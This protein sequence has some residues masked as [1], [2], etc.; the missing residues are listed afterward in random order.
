MN[1]V[2]RYFQVQV[3]RRCSGVLHAGVILAVSLFALADAW[4]LQVTPTTLS[5]LAVQGSTSPSGQIL[6]ILKKNDRTLNWSS[7]DNATWL[8][9]SPT[10]GSITS[11]AQISV[12]V[13]PAGLGAGTYTGTITVSV[14]KGGS[15]SVPVTLTVTSGSTSSTSTSLSSSSGTATL[16]WDP[17]TSTNVA[18]YKVYMGTASGTYSAS[19]TVES[20]TTYTVSNLGVGST[21]Y[22]AVTAYNTS[23]IESSFSN[24][25][26][27]SI[28]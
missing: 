16:T 15:I 25:V 7:S 23:G 20:T 5:F 9:V 4:A 11:S 1:E 13:N 12:S 17:S 18:G 26:S 27:K 21:Y 24:E 6:N 2:K 8:H 10:T 22:F 19:I 14:T 28:Y 3:W